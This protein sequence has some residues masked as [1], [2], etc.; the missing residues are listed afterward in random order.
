[1]LSILWRLL[2]GLLLNRIYEILFFILQMNP[3]NEEYIRYAKWVK[4]QIG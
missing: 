4:E 1:M 2:R 3:K